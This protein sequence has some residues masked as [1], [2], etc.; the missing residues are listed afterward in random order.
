MEQ[1]LPPENVTTQN[2]PHKVWVRV[3]C[4]TRMIYLRVKDIYLI[5]SIT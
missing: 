4:L 2:S 3:L 5:L 1:S